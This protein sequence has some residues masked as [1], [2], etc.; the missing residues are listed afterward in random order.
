MSKHNEKFYYQV[1]NKQNKVVA[2]S[3]LYNTMPGMAFGMNAAMK[4]VCVAV[5]EDF[6]HH[7]C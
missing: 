5:I 7:Y 4:N 3:V 1:M 6:R 2:T